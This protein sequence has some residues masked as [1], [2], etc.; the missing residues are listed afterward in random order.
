MR[1][2]PFVVLLA[3][4]LHAGTIAD[5]TSATSVLLEPGDSLAFQVLCWNFG[6]NATSFALDLYPTDIIFTFVTAPV[7]EF[8]TLSAWL[9]SP[10]GS[11]SADFAG[12]LVFTPGLFSSS[13]YRGTVSTLRAY[14][15]LAPE[16]SADI[17]GAGSAFLVLRNDGD[18]QMLGLPPNTLRQDLSVSLT[19]GPLS[20]GAISGSVTLQSDVPEPATLLPGLIALIVIGLGGDTRN[21]PFA[22]RQSSLIL[23]R[24]RLES[25]RLQSANPTTELTNQPE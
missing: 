17:F 15:H 8:A 3:L 18:N 14:L 20:V 10:G 19:G 4:P 23:S 16:L 13:R 5:A 21:Q 25:S 6:Y 2:L 12:P 24:C 7:S 11:A 22:N 1:L 9:A